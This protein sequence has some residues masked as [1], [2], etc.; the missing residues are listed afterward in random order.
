MKT[1]SILLYWIR[2]FD[3]L[4]GF[5]QSDF[6]SRVRITNNHNILNFWFEYYNNVFYSKKFVWNFYNNYSYSNFACDMNIHTLFHPLIFQNKEQ[7]LFINWIMQ[8][9][10][11]NKLIRLLEFKHIP[12]DVS[13]WIFH[14]LNHHWTIKSIRS[15]NK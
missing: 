3:Y 6:F 4:F 2:S 10:N 5:F 7:S 1:T 14:W 15:W 9:K 13:K 8:K 12:G 11:L